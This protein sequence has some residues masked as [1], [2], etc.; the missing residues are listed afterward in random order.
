MKN[1]LWEI[2]PRLEGNSVVTSKW[3]YKKKHV[4]DRSIN[5]YKTRFVARGFSQLLRKMYEEPY[6][7]IFRSCWAKAR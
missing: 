6:S 4:V 5:K 7:I 3:A 1:D 2:V